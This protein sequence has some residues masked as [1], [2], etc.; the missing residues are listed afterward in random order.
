MRPSP[1]Q[2]NQLFFEKFLIEVNAELLEKSERQAFPSGSDEF[3]GV[4]LVSGVTCFPLTGKPP[5]AEQDYL[6][7]LNFGIPN[8]TG[9]Q[10]RYAVDVVVVGAFT[11]ISE[12]IPSSER[13]NFVLVNGASLL[14]G[15]IRD[16][17]AALSAR[18][19]PGQLLLPTVNFLD[20]KTPTLPA[21][22]SPATPQLET[23][24]NQ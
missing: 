4:N 3:E 10:C 12:K 17:V 2:L 8:D 15:A 13:E 22:E 14:Y 9:T 1:L 18:S 16:Q 6:V 20:L 11:V 21:G 19:L 23:G 24:S 7:R 5:E